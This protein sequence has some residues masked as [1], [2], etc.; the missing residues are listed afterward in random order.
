MFITS[1][2]S[3]VSVTTIGLTP[4]ADTQPQAD[5][6]KYNFSPKYQQRMELGQFSVRDRAAKHD[7]RK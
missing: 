5:G 7:G 6:K 2:W 4:I 3:T 1:S